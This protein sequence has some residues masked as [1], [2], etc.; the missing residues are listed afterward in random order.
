VGIRAVVFLINPAKSA[1]LTK[2]KTTQ[3]YFKYMEF[4]KTLVISIFLL[5]YYVGCQ[6][7]ENLNLTVFSDQNPTDTPFSA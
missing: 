2:K 4:I 1:D 3:H 5:V 6:I 7:N